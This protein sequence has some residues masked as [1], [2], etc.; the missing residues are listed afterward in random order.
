MKFNI[1][2]T[3]NGKPQRTRLFIS[4]EDFNLYMSGDPCPHLN[5]RQK[6]ALLFFKLQNQPT[7]AHSLAGKGFVPSKRASQKLKESFE[8]MLFLGVQAEICIAVYGLAVCR[9]E[10][11]SPK[12]VDIQLQ[13]HFLFSHSDIPQCNHD[14]LRSVITRLA[15]PACRTSWTL[16]KFFTFHYLNNPGTRP[17]F[18]FIS[19]WAPSEV[20]GFSLALVLREDKMEL[21]FLGLYY[22]KKKKIVSDF[23]CQE[24]IG[25]NTPPKELEEK[26]KEALSLKNMLPHKKKEYD[27][28]L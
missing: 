3:G 4:E 21:D 12:N 15:V 18:E 25:R 5:L 19:E 1:S 20:L 14:Y 9:T 11:L 22:P 10:R 26:I 13:E 24:I 2:I 17:K 28:F 23:I 8:R 7:N 16:V 6:S 27:D